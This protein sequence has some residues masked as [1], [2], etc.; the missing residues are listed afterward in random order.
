MC[1]LSKNHTLNNHIKPLSRL[2]LALAFRAPHAIPDNWMQ[3]LAAEGST[4][5]HE[6]RGLPAGTER[7]VHQ[8][9]EEVSI[10]IILQI[11][12]MCDFFVG[13]GWRFKKDVRTFGILDSFVVLTLIRTFF[14]YY[15]SLR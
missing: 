6:K 8:G 4:E 15:A 5:V 14:S 10:L 3:N 2:V 12:V 7:V 11:S 1:V 13:L 9:Y